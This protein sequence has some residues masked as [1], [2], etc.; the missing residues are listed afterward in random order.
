MNLLIGSKARKA[1]FFVKTCSI[2]IGKDSD[3]RV[4]ST[5]KNNQI[6]YLKK[7]I[8]GLRVKKASLAIM[9]FL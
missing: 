3:K 8:L 6:T 2:L 1:P 4:N 9:A 7:V 5:A